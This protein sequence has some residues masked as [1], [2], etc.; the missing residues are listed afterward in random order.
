MP[1][2][3]KTAIVTHTAA[4]MFRLVNDIE[5]YPSF[6]PWCK[7]SQVLSRTEDEIRAMLNFARSGMEKSFTTL[8]RLQSD[9][10]IEISLIDGPFKHLRGFWQF[11]NLPGNTCQVSLDLE[12]EFSN[13]LL[14]LA[15][16]PVFTQV[17][18]A[19]VDAF[20]KRADEI[21]GI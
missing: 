8:N 12:F 15:F 18:N 5:A 16:G 6:I 7:S 4:E 21:Y 2:I 10:M 20:H 3:K 19:L 14:G 9:K 11:D 17:A 1:D 13:K